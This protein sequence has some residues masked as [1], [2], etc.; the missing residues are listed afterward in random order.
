MFVSLFAGFQHFGHLQFTH[1]SIFASG[2]SQVQDGSY[3]STF[4]KV[5]GK[6]S[7]FSGTNP[8]SSQWTTGIGS[9][10]YLWREKTQSLNLK[11]VFFFQ[12]LFSSANWDNLFLASFEVK[13]EN[14][15]EFIKIQSLVKAFFEISHQEIYSI[16]SKSYFFANSKSLSSCAGTAIT[17]QVQ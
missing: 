12:K 10:Q 9:H 7:S 1:S 6:F 15:Q 14:S 3:F 17:A 2:D 5:K 13:S 8:Q 16:I 4:G 11:F